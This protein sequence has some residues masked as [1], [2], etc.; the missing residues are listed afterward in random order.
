MCVSVSV[1]VN[2]CVWL[3][4]CMCVYAYLYVRV[5]V[6]SGCV[7]WCAIGGGDVCVRVRL[8]VK[9]SVSE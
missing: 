9:V 2:V 1:S 8:T 4:V 3:L 7:V 5:P 6:C